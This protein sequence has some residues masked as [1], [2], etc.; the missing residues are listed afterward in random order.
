[1]K[2]LLIMLSKF[3][4]LGAR[5]ISF[6]TRNRYTHASIALEEDPSTF[7]SFSLKGFHIEHPKGLLKKEYEAFPCQVNAINVPDS[8]YSTAKKLIKTFTSRKEEYKYAKL[9][10]LFALFHIPFS[11]NRHFFCSHFVAE[12]LGRSGAIHLNK[13]SCLYMPGDLQKI[14]G[15]S[16]IFSGSIQEYARSL[17]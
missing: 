10:I 5:I 1:M 3:S 9:G 16:T 6:L 2:K 15:V 11:I 13:K 17:A 4:D 12:I 7:Y 8:I 14:E